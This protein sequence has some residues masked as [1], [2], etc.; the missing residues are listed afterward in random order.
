MSLSATAHKIFSSCVSSDER[1]KQ[2]CTRPEDRVRI[3][4]RKVE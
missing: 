1:I 4:T 2:S 3:E